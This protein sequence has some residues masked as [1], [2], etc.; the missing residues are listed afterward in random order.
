MAAG[1]LQETRTSSKGP[2]QPR[3][4]RPLPLSPPERPGSRGGRSP[5]LSATTTTWLESS[6]PRSCSGFDPSDTP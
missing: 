3:R 2:G 6:L 5:A 4:N 1:H